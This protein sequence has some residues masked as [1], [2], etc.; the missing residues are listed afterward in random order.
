MQS[1]R[2]LHLLKVNAR[3]GNFSSRRKESRFFQV[4]QTI[5]FLSRA[6]SSTAGFE[7]N[8]G[9]IE[10]EKENSHRFS[11]ESIQTASSSKSDFPN[12]KFSYIV[13]LLCPCF[14][15]DIFSRI[16]IFSSRTKQLSHRYLRSNVC[17]I[18][19]STLIAIR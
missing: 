10:A 13:G 4:L 14:C 3:S 6:S 11:M 19:W 7:E 2:S 17:L 18:I 5:G 9:S 16:A 1:V 12:E 8:N 15:C